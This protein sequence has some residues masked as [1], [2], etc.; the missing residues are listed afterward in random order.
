MDL[1]TFYWQPETDSRRFRRTARFR[2][3]NAGDSF[4]IDLAAWRY[5]D[6]P[7]VNDG[8]ETGGRLLM[9]G[10]TGHRALDGDLL[11]GVGLKQAELPVRDGR[12]LSIHGLRGPMSLE[13]FERAG[14]D[15]SAV[16]FLGDPGLLIGQVF[17]QL[18]RI[19]AARGRVSYLP[20]YREKDG[21]RS[22]RRRRII[23]I[24][25]PALE[26]GRRIARSEVVVSSSLHGIIWAH[27]LG[28]PVRPVGPPKGEAPFKFHDYFAS[29]GAVYRPA[30]SV[31]EALREPI[32]AVPE[33]VGAAIEGIVLP[34]ADAL[35][36]RG[37]LR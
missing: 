32:P 16:R 5:P 13:A 29:I 9:V 6:H 21:L 31:E 12:D 27:A 20:H 26:V 24:D 30:T 35:R 10:S 37:V 17:P 19:A 15:T 25:A 1:R 34:D 4:N 3:G 23:D 2:Y 8:A 7:L 33:G 28:R 22:D 14:H 11:S 18:G 36:S